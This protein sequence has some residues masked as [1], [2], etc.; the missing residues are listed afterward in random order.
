MVQALLRK[1]SE[2]ALRASEERWRSIFETS[3]LGISIFD[4]DLRYIAAN[5]AFRAM[6]GY[7]DEELR[8]LTP[9]DITV[10]EGRETGQ[11]RTR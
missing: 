10:E 2:A 3:A 5:P 11:I 1:R 9:L 7:T 6:L 8:Q 4:Q